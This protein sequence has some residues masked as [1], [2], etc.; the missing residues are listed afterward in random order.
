MDGWA[1]EGITGLYRIGLGVLGCLQT[2]LLAMR[3][4]QMIHYLHNLPDSGK[5]FPSHPFPHRSI[6]ECLLGDFFF[7]SFSFSNS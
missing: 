4:E 1:A 7:F 6:A 5:A 2:T 3:E